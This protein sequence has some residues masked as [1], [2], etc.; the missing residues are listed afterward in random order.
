MFVLLSCW[1]AGIAYAD[2]FYAPASGVKMLDIS[3][4]DTIV[5]KKGT[6]AL[7]EF[8]APWCGH[9]KQLKPEYVAAAKQLEGTVGVFAVD[10]SD[11]ENR[12]L[13]Q[14]Y[15]VQGFPTIKVFVGKKVLDYSGQRTGKAMADFALGKLPSSVIPV[16]NA[17]L[18]DFLAKDDQVRVLLFT[19][20]GKSALYKA[21]SGQFKEYA[22]LGEVVKDKKAAKRY[23]IDFKEKSVVLLFPKGSSDP[24]IYGG[25]LT[26]KPL[27]KFIKRFVPEMP[28][29]AGDNLARITDQSC[30]KMNCAKK[31]LCVLLIT[32]SDEEENARTHDTV[33]EVQDTNHQASLFAFAQIDGV[34][35]R[36]W[37]VETFGNLDE[38]TPQLVVMSTVKFRY[39]QYRGSFSSNS[40]ADFVTGVLNGKTR[41]ARLR[42]KDSIPE[43]DTSSENCKPPPKPKKKPKQQQQQQQ[44][45]GGGAGPG[46]GSDYLV[47]GT[48]DD[49]EELV[50]ESSQPAMIE[51]YAPWCGHC[52]NL[53]PQWAAA[54]DKVKGMVQFV[55]VDCTVEEEVCGE[56]GVQGFPTIKMKPAGAHEGDLMDFRGGRDANALKK[57]A[58][59]LLKNVYV[60]RIDDS[61]MDDFVGDSGTRFLLFSEKD[62][63]P[64]MLRALAAK[65]E[66]ASWQIT[67]S[68]QEGLVAKFNVDAFPK[69][70]AYTPESGENFITYEGKV[71]FSMIGA[72]VEDIGVS[73]GGGAGHEDD[74]DEPAEPITIP[75]LT[76]QE[77]LDE[78]CKGKLLCFISMLGGDEIAAARNG[79]SEKMD[80]VA[81]A[82][83]KR[84]IG[85]FF[86]FGWI[87]RTRFG[88]F[89]KAFKG[90]PTGDFGA[91]AV[92]LKRK[93]YVVYDGA[94][95]VEFLA[96]L[97]E[98][99][100]KT[101]KL[102][103]VP[104]LVE[105]SEATGKDEL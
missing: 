104:V 65:Y 23:D 36:K 76:G 69:I 77:D 49:F 55:T 19:N 102:T 85:D 87:D 14:R 26:A 38:F 61:D 42:S 25:S 70:V 33:L 82:A 94:P 71:D 54:A 95:V 1:I 64:T 84:D 56:Y 13:A 100:G 30:F 18:D 62:K 98:G 8:F 63:I 3:N 20:K 88:S 91:V 39:A 2:D 67:S 22:R 75:E 93:A 45:G 41:T 96:N 52:K 51:F 53:A 48:D 74:D 80:S 59:K 79:E 9:C 32:S 15:G 44:H 34:K 29:M 12:E 24:S 16:T 6:V 105:D 4:F 101:K 37:V 43:L 97:K 73:G 47:T 27:R 72:W 66:S 103:K 17:D 92:A 31:G 58:F 40:V 68:T 60:S 83:N 50:L 11:D 5:G 78:A 81:S 10:A 46:K 21:L 86:G 57:A 35:E 7:V 99:K 28:D 89:S 90:V